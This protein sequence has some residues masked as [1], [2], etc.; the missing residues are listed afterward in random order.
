MPA[1]LSKAAPTKCPTCGAPATPTSGS[2]LGRPT[3][4]TQAVGRRI[5]TAIRKGHD[6]SS[7]ARLAKVHPATL[8]HWLRRG[9]A[10]EEPYAELAMKVREAEERY[11]SK[12]LGKIETAQIPHVTGNV[13]DWRAVAWVLSRRFPNRY[14]DR[15]IAEAQM[16]DRTQRIF[17]AIEPHVSEGAYRELLEALLLVMGGVAPQREAEAQMIDVEVSSPEPDDG[18]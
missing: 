8:R 6:A 15:V 13:V 3:L 5:V 17:E 4:L 7:A 10:G 11:A 14:S 1:E 18:R 2:Q 9:D 12:L 16:K